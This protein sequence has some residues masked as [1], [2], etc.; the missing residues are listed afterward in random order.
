MRYKRNEA[1]RYQLNDS[2]DAIFTLKVEEDTLSSKG[3][4]LIYNISPNG[5]RFRTEY[6]LPVGDS[7]LLLQLQFI[8][9]GNEIIMPGHITWKKKIGILFEYGFEGKENNEAKQKIINGLKELSRIDNKD[10]L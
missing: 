2:L 6:D 9:N 3:H 7:R 10:T 8:L 1:F 4:A 5:L